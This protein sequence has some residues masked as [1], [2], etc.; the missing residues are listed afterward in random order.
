MVRETRF[1]GAASGDVSHDALEVADLFQHCDVLAED[2]DIQLH[3]PP[4]SRRNSSRVPA[5][6]TS[7]E[8]QFHPEYG[9][10]GHQLSCPELR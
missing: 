2:V 9:E 1:S 7:A 5:A 4:R 6:P 10:D 3:A 8:G